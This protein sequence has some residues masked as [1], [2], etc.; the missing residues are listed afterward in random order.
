MEL[1]SALING[2]LSKRSGD[3]GEKWEHINTI[4]FTEDGRLGICNTDFEG[5]PF[6]LK[7]FA[8]FGRNQP[9]SATT[10]TGGTVYTL[11]TT[12]P[13]V[14]LTESTEYALYPN[15]SISA[16]VTNYWGC[17]YQI[18]LFEDEVRE[19]GRFV[20]VSGTKPPSS[21]LFK[22]IPE[23]TKGFRAVGVYASKANTY[24]GAGSTVEIYGVRA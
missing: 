3:N 15:G 22:E 19:K 7:K 8:M 1:W 10:A 16:T 9:T 23:G 5:N 21:N 6:E 13:D 18:E 17:C 11:A 2:E 4:T 20:I 14:V 12:N 24:L